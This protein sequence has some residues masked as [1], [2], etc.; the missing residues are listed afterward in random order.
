MS[1]KGDHDNMQN[2][3]DSTG[4]NAVLDNTQA[5]GPDYDEINDEPSTELSL[6][7]LQEE[8]SVELIKSSNNYFT[9]MLPEDQEN[10]SNVTS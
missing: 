9:L 5:A 7:K 2:V 1:V 4:Y 10:T 6:E 8:K 3:V